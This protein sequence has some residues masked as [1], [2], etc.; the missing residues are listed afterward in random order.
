LALG[1]FT[2]THA[3]MLRWF[4]QRRGAGFALRVLAAQVPHHLCNGVSLVLGTLLWSAQ[5]WA[6][7]RTRW[8]LAPDPWPPSSTAAASRATSS[9]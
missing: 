7:W 6:G 4:A 2:A 1:G 3:A 9:R 8:T 5:R